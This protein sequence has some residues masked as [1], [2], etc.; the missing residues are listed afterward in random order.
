MKD[1]RSFNEQCHDELVAALD[2]VYR[3]RQKLQKDLLDTYN[4][5]LLDKIIMLDKMIQDAETLLNKKEYVKE[6]YSKR[7]PEYVDEDKN[8][9][10]RGIERL[11]TLKKKWKTLG[12]LRKKP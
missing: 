4:E 5:E 7:Y 1:L 3:I 6:F 2:K 10:E 9:N 12:Y 11:R 8:I